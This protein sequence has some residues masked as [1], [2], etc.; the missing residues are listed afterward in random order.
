MLGSG[1]DRRHEAHLARMERWAIVLAGGDGTR[2][3][4]LPRWIAGDDRRVLLA[5][6]RGSPQ[7]ALRGSGLLK[8]ERTGK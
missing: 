6:G 7:G 2:V 3:G 8:R 5:P 4:D 1:P